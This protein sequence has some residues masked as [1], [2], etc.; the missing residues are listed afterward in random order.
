MMINL[1]SYKNYHLLIKNYPHIFPQDDFIASEKFYLSSGMIINNDYF[2]SNKFFQ[3]DNYVEFLINIKYAS[4]M[5]KMMNILRSIFITLILIFVSLAINND[6]SKFVVFPVTKIIKKF[7]YFLHKSTYDYYESLIYN[8]NEEEEIILNKQFA[9]FSYY[10]DLT[11]G[12]RILRLVSQMDD[13]KNSSFNFSLCIPGFSFIGTALILDIQINNY[14]D[15]SSVIEDINKIFTIF[16]SLGFGFNGEI[17]N[18]ST[19]FWKLKDE[20]FNYHFNTYSRRISKKF[21]LIF[22]KKFSI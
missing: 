6:L 4:V 17:L 7:R 11:I 8:D 19:I 14:F 12:K 20:S 3:K 15:F 21:L 5:D 18:E 13:L 16:H 22:F 1:T 2:Y 10:F 9:T